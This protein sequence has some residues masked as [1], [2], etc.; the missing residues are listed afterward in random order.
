MN[1]RKYT[2]SIQ[3]VFNQNNPMFTSNLSIPNHVGQLEFFVQNCTWVPLWGPKNKN[4]GECHPV[5]TCIHI[6]MEN[7]GVDQALVGIL[8]PQCEPSLSWNQAS[9]S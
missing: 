4:L 1:T 7:R 5:Y 9:I 3:C 2:C 8:V 6:G